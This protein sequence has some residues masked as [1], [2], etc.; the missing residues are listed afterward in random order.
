MAV[1]K[2][3]LVIATS[4]IPAEEI[5]SQVAT[6]FGAG[7]EL[8]VVAP[9]SGLSRIDWLTNAEDDARA[10]AEQRA[11]ELAAA[12]PRD[13]VAAGVGDTDPLQAIEDALVGFP[14]DEIVVITRP[15]DE[16]TWLESGTA[17]E[18]R[19]RFELPVTHLVAR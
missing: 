16:T 17:R 11:E 7:S 15:E 19:E 18:A 3:V 6:R 2:R 1:P 9:A 12:L 14:A 4:A 10:D 13:D 5:G 8:R